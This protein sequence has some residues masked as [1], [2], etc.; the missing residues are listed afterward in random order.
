[1]IEAERVVE[2]NFVLD[3]KLDPDANSGAAS[4]EDISL[5]AYTFFAARLGAGESADAAAATS[6]LLDA[7]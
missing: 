7:L 2:V 4:N 6:L 3:L 5:K 1:M